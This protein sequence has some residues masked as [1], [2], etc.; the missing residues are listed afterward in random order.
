MDRI[1]PLQQP[2]GHT[3]YGVAFNNVDPRYSNVFACVGGEKARV[4]VVDAEPES[5][6][7][8][9]SD[10]ER[11]PERS[12]TVDQRAKPLF[13]LVQEYVDGRGLVHVPD[14]QAGKRGERGEEYYCCA[15]SCAANG[16]PLLCFGGKLAI[17]KVVNYERREVCSAL[18][19][20]G[21]EINEIKP[22]PTKF[23]IILST[24]KDQSV[25]VWNVQTSTVVMI[26]AGLDGH[27]AAVYTADFHQREGTLIASGSEDHTTKIWDLS[28]HQDLVDLSFK[29]Y[30]DKGPPG[31]FPTAYIQTPTFSTVPHD[32]Y[33]DCVC[34][35]GDLLLTKC[36]Q[37]HI[38]L[39][40]PEHG[41][42]GRKGRSPAPEDLQDGPPRHL[43]HE[44]LDVRVRPAPAPRRAGQLRGEGAGVGGGGRGHGAQGGHEDD[45]RH[46]GRREAEGDHQADL[47]LLGREASRL[48]HRGGQ[49]L[50]VENQVVKS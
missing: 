5:D 10:G 38:I 19:G 49:S 31:S 41:A 39:W 22:H 2:V 9:G 47:V 23:G 29:W 36:T 37:G 21:M 8:K 30:G 48:R 35:H 25:R 7:P 13:R 11:R 44:V 3:M 12:G 40:R 18:Q 14:G 1:L 28:G 42:G 15:W 16:D 24:S 46:E 43:L 26:L 6:P 27:K 32:N 17:I 33:V 34:W 4:F 45:G 20:H 50:P